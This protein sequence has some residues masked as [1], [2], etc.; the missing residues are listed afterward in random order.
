MTTFNHLNVPDQWNQYFT[1]Y[2]QGYTI[3]EALLNWVQQVDNM[4]DNVNSWNTYL[5]NFVKSFD[6]DLQATVEKTLSDWQAS[7]FLDTVITNALQTDALNIGAVTPERYGAKGDG[8]TDDTPAITAAINAIKDGTAKT[9]ILELKSTYKGNVNLSQI[10]DI[11]VRGKGK[12][13]GSI[14]VSG[15]YY[16]D[17][18]LRYSG[19][20]DITIQ[21]ITIDG[22][23]AGNGISL[24]YVFGV[25]IENVLF[26]DLANGVF[27]PDHN[28]N[29]HVS[30]AKIKNSRFLNCGVALRAQTTGVALMTGDLQ[31]IGNYCETTYAP[32]IAN[33]NG[34]LIDHVD[35]IQIA[36]NV[37][38]GDNANTSEHI[39]ID[40]GTWVAIENNQVFLGKNNGVYVSNVQNL[41]IV[42]N[43]ICWQKGHAV[44]LTN[45]QALKVS[46]NLISWRSAPNDVTYTGHGINI[47]HDAGG[48]SNTWGSI[49]DNTIIMPTNLGIYANT[50]GKLNI[51]GNTIIAVNNSNPP[52]QLDYCEFSSV[53]NSLCYGFTSKININGGF[54]AFEFNT[55]YGD[56]TTYSE[57]VPKLR[58]AVYQGNETTINLDDIDVI[59]FTNPAA[60]TVT[61]FTL[62]DWTTP[63]K[64]LMY[65]YNDNT[66]IS[67]AIPNVN[68]YGSSGSVN[69]A[70]NG[71]IEFLA[72][73]GS[74]HE[75]NRNNVTAI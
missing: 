16:A 71:S 27:I 74:L 51:N 62:T 18:N 46:D 42:D 40:N 39:R 65:S 50:V 11:I 70:S 68:I 59:I 47:M 10:S 41:K 35:G 14:I 37:F 72:Y 66:N 73:G 25:K 60:T 53:I 61:A 26:K 15:T 5:D 17:A 55:F 69:M 54:N 23:G 32:L 38:F 19:N 56:K 52:I 75:I 49:S 7:G 22:Q 12:L 64:I 28:Y 2:P 1:K 24:E 8:V 67:R 13:L 4:T 43:M 34:V 57:F 9:R 31:F 6:A 3:L 30:R 33:V 36:D 44:S 20:S 58:T 45:I 29:Q 63:R 21:D 48:D